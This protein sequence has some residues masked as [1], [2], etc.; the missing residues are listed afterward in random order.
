MGDGPPMHPRWSGPPGDSKF[1]ESLKEQALGFGSVAVIERLQVQT[2]F[3][4]F[5]TAT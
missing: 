3:V 4:S 1:I 5:L 2:V